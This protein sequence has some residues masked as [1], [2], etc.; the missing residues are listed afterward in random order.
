MNRL[1]TPR[2]VAESVMAM[3]VR[4]G[5][6]AALD[7]AGMKRHSKACLDWLGGALSTSVIPTDRKPP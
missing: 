4:T 6:A 2:E 5:R 1:V 7:D 3:I